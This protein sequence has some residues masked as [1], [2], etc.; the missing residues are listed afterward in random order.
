MAWRKRWGLPVLLGVVLL[1]LVCL[2]AILDVGRYGAGVWQTLRTSC[3][4]R[5]AAFETS[6]EEWIVRDDLRSIDAAAKLLLMGSGQYVDVVVRGETVTS[7]V[8]EGIGVEAI[9]AAAEPPSGTTVHERGGVIEILSPIALAGY[10]N[11]AIGFFRIGFS[12]DYAAD[13]VRH[14]ALVVGAIA[15][16]CCL[17]CLGVLALAIWRARQA[18]RAAGRDESVLHCGPL[19]IDRR[20]CTVRFDGQPLDLTP[21]LFEL[22]SVFAQSPGVVFSDDELLQAVWSDSAYAASSDVKQH[23]YLLRRKFSDVHPCP[24]SLIENV[25]GFGYR[26][27]PTANEKELSSY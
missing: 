1:A 12:D 4:R 9:D 16:G 13:R 11:T 2:F 8:D 7:G 14:R 21:K 24:K 19:E 22:L 18:T 10:P 3:L 5:A 6:V 23:I 20:S 25:K 15:T 17:V 27:V 26:L